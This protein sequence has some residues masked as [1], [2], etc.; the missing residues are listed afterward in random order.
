MKNISCIY[1]IKNKYL[2]FSK[3]KL[4]EKNLLINIIGRIISK[5]KMK[6]NIFINIQ[7]IQENIQILINKN[8]LIKNKYLNIKNNIKIGNFIYIRGYIYKTN[9]KEL[10]IKC[11]NYKILKK[12]NKFLP[13][14]HNKLKKKEKKYRQR[15][16]DLIIN[17]KTRKTFLKRIK[18]INLIRKFLNKKKFLEIET[19]ILH[20][21][22]GGANAKPFKTY[23][24]KLNMEIYLRISPELYLKKLIIGGFTKIFEL[25]KSFR[26]EGI[27]KYH[28]PEFSMLE[29]YESYTNY[30]N[31]MS[32]TENIFNYL[33]KK[34]YKNKKKISF[35]KYKI[36]FNT[37]YRKITIKQAIYKYSK[38]FNNIEEIENTKI[39]IKKAKKININTKNYSI[40]EIILKIFE[41]TTEKYLIQPTF[42]TNYPTDV[43]PLSKSNITNYNIADRFELFIGGYEIGNGFSELNDDKEQKK[44]FKQQKKN[45]NSTKKNFFY[46]KEYINALKYGLPPTSGVGLGIDRIV[47]LLTN[48]KSIKDVILFPLLKEI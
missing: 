12:I 28:N 26:N 20:P 31:M 42:I 7:D 44:R 48:N 21:I 16:L 29:I 13:D 18:I 22:P 8:F 41:S 39:I 17:K 45:K 19:P 35:N 23:H 46:D 40:G 15:Y 1:K 32:L 34:I 3:K 33:I 9:T 6:K 10:T 38:L 25:N 11:K 5:R 43:S 24:N 4:E 47:M 27:S 14:K 2:N 30:K 36:N 37:P